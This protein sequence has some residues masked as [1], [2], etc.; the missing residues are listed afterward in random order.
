M[1]KIDLE[2]AYYHFELHPESRDI[3][4]FVARSGVYRFR[5]L[6]FGI[7]SAPELFQREM[8]SVFRGIEGLIVY[9]D[10]LLLHGETEEA[11]D[12][13]LEEVMKRIAEMKLKINEQKSVFGVSELSFLG[14]HISE[15]GI[16][17]TGDKIQ[18]IQNL[19]PPKSKISLGIDQFPGQIRS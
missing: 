2:A 12:R 6:M 18:A 5:R 7:K 14:Y 8:E 13:T 15:D 17:P 9:M 11:H 1:S 16:R 4:T 3:T 19:Q 10:D